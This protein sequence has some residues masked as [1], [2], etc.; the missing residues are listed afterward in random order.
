M[1]LRFDGV[2]HHCSQCGAFAAKREDVRCDHLTGAGSLG[3]EPVLGLMTPDEA[4]LARIRDTQEIL[5]DREWRWKAQDAARQRAVDAR[6]KALA[7]PLSHGAPLP[8][9]T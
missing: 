3:G 5:N 7:V 4:A 6:A 1:E 8:R 2:F 9:L